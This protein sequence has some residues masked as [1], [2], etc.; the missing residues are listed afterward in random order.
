MAY[1][2][3][4]AR[5]LGTRGGGAEPALTFWDPFLH[6]FLKVRDPFGAPLPP[7]LEAWEKFSNTSS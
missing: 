2:R 3:G 7:L 6:D 5:D 1:S 4:V